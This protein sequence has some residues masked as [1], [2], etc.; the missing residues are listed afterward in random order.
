MPIE[1]PTLGD[2]SYL[3][4]DG[5][6]AVVT[7]GARGTGAGIARRLA[8]AGAT[9]V[10]ADADAAVALSLVLIV[11]AA[12]IVIASTGRRLVGAP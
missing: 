10:V 12:V 9:V 4:H 2:R 7:G 6:V 5:R 8:E 1:T 3:I 11:V